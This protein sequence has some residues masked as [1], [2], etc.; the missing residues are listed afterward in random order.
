[1]VESQLTLSK[2]IEDNR[3]CVMNTSELETYDDS[4]DDFDI[5]LKKPS[6]ADVDNAERLLSMLMN[7]AEWLWRQAK[8]SDLYLEKGKVEKETTSGYSYT[9][10]SPSAYYKSKK[11]KSLSLFQIKEKVRVKEISQLQ[12]E[13]D[14][15]LIFLSLEE[16][17]VKKSTRPVALIKERLIKNSMSH[18]IT[19]LFPKGITMTNSES[20]EGNCIGCHWDVHLTEENLDEKILNTLYGVL[21]QSSIAYRNNHVNCSMANKVRE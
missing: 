18:G 21:A 14:L 19:S 17:D 9:L 6:K 7:N 5:I 8:E 12:V 10:V 1:M 13:A 16:R 2:N 11:D 4:E 3:L 15:F 20:E